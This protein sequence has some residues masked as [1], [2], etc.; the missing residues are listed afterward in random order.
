MRSPGGWVEPGQTPQF[1]EFTVVVKGT[2]RVEY[3]D[4]ALDVSA[5]QAVIAYKGEW[6]R[7]ST[8]GEEGAEYFAVCLPAFSMDTVNRDEA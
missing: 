2:L 6:V 1:D 4:G 8:P 3:R 5:G 7:Y